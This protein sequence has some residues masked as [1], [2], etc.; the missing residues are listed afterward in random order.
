MSRKNLIGG[1]IAAFIVSAPVMHAAVADEVSDFYKGKTV[2][3]VVG[4]EAGTGFDIY[5]RVVIRHMGRHIPGNPDMLVQNMPGA[6]GIVS[7]NWLY[8]IAPKDGTVMAI[9][10]QNVPLEPLFGNK[11]AKF[12][13]AKMVWVGN[14]EKSVAVCGVSK[15]A[16]VKSFA[17]LQNKET[18]FGATG[19]TGPLMKSALA[20]K[21]LLGAKI[22]II[23]GYKGS[24]SVKN[25]MQRGEV[26]GICGLPWST[27]KSFWRQEV[28]SGDFF[29]ILQLSGE[30]SAELGGIAHVDDFIKNDEQRKLFN[31][32]FGVQA[33]GRAYVLPPDVPKARIGAL[34]KAFMATMADAQFL[35]DAKKTDIDI[36]PSPGEVVDKMWAEFTSTPQS[37]IARVKQVVTPPK[38]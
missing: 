36:Q 38:K 2:T 8:N 14:M 26:M 9:F 7:A 24:A 25:A 16:G 35:A 34:R 11:R 21:N 10:T 33:L 32:I 23:S 20:V 3:I 4:H 27:V 29:P 1:A 18:V 13:T 28:Q 5:S 30:R 31:I 6:S 17:D 12:D 37:I 22:R 19:A 15:A